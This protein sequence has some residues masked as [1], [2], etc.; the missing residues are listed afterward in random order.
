MS[1]DSRPFR[2]I[3]VPLDG[4]P[5]AEQALPVATELAARAGS[6][7]RLVLVHQVPSAPLNPMSAHRF[8]GIELASR[9]SERAYLRV[10]QA[11]LRQQGVRLSTA[12]TLTGPVGLALA[13][14]VRE[15][16]TD[17]VVMATHG[18]GGVRRAWLGS[19]ADY[20]V[21]H[22]EV[23]VLLVRASEGAGPGPAPRTGGRILVALDGSALA[24]QALE[25][26][27]AMARFRDAEVSLIQVV[28][29]VLD[30]PDQML[31]MPAG[32]DH[33]LTGECRDQAQDYLDDLVERLRGDGLRAGAV[34]VVG[35]SIA[36]TLLEAAA[37]P[38][39]T[40]VVVATHGRGGL[41]RLALGSVADKLVRAATVPVLVQRPAGRG[42]TREG[43]APRSRKLA[44]ART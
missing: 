27:A 24:E 12:A 22:L 11:R 20:L 29:P 16:R 26:A 41:K 31:P 37:A 4:S 42:Q 32:Y 35:W 13:E 40:M 36:G 1:F 34:A 14:H 19:V 17:L 38:D 30:V 10:V 18:R 6:K 28:P 8:T 33:A 44:A 43:G 23:P 2:T 21:R 25:A 7:V 5:L 3:M 39:V 9:K 15:L